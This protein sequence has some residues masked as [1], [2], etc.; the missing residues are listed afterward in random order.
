MEPTTPATVSAREQVT[1]LMVRLTLTLDEPGSWVSTGV[2]DEFVHVDVA[3]ETVDADGH[4]ARH[5]TVSGLVENGFEMEVF[6]HG[7]GAGAT[8][9]RDAKVG[10]S[11]LVSDPKEY[12]EVPEG[13]G[14]RVLVGDVTTIPAIARILADARADEVF[15]V[16]IELPGMGERRTFTTAAD[17]RID[18]RVGG[19]GIGPSMICDALRSLAAEG[20][21]DPAKQPYVWVAGESKDTRKARALLR[22]EVGLPIRQQRIVGYWHAGLE[23][24]LEAWE[25]LSDDLKATYLSIWR[26]DRSDEENWLEL[27]PFLQS[28]GH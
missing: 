14:V 2:G 10:D 3:A 12:Y 11:V 6:L 23:Q 7:D 9:A 21:L 15:R 8:W 16:V 22:N 24:I 25:A 27:E 5:Y 4:S 13:S 26:D 18:W 19:N 1:P 20:V 28:V 17:V